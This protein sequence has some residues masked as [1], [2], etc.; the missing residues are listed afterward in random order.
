MFEIV[1]SSSFNDRVRNNDS[2]KQANSRNTLK[3]ITAQFD[4]FF[5]VI[6]T[7]LSPEKCFPQ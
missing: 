5:D 3:V 4:R 6:R 2:R 7:I 1:M